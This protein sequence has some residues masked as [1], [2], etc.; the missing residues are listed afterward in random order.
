MAV[1]SL[2]GQYRYARALFFGA[3]GAEAD[4]VEAIELW[5]DA[6]DRGHISSQIDYAN[7]LMDG[8]FVEQNLSGAVHYF[9]LAAQQG[10][11]DGKVFLGQMYASGFGVP[12]NKVEAARLYKEAADSGDRYGQFRFGFACLVGVGVPLNANR[13]AR[14]LRAAAEQGHVEAKFLYGRLL[15]EGRGVRRNLMEAVRLYGEAAEAGFVRS[16]LEYGYVFLRGDVLPRNYTEAAKWF[17]L[18]SDAGNLDAHVVYANLI[19]SGSGV[20]LNRTEAARLYRIAADGAHPR[21]MTEY[22]IACLRG[23]GVPRNLTEAAAYFEQAA[24]R[25]WVW[26]F[27]YSGQVLEE[28]GPMQNYTEAAEWYKA[29]AAR[30][31][32]ECLASLGNLF[33]RGL[34]VEKNLTHGMRLLHGVEQRNVIEALLYLGAIHEEGLTGEVDLRAGFRYFDLAANLSAEE[35]AEYPL[36]EDTR[37]KDGREALLRRNWAKIAEFARELVGKKVTR[38]VARMVGCAAEIGIDGAAKLAQE[39]V[40]GDAADGAKVSAADAPKEGA[41]FVHPEL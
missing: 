15:A 11:A 13:S 30:D 7:L 39:L 21:G 31:H 36:E 5:R 35:A 32:H 22:G 33:V 40:G 29:G 4:R 6:A 9:G 26:G 28:P 24:N 23:L 10:S 8:E 27:W 2:D 38:E 17:K 34:G 12:E 14:Y 20:P 18:A 19:G 1:G 41:D 37:G 25:N 16:Q 3:G